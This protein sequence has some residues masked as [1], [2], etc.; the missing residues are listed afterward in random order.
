ME[1]KKTHV[2]PVCGMQVEE[3]LEAITAEY[4]GV[5]YYFCAPGCKLSFVREPEKYLRGGEQIKM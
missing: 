2:D 5:T 4:K 3:D 1:T